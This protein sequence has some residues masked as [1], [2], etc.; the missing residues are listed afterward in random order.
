MNPST[1]S[2]KNI[3]EQVEKVLNTFKAFNVEMELSEV[4]DG[5]RAL[6][7][8]LKTKEPVRM[9]AI[10][11]FKDDL[12]YALGSK[13]IEIE[14]PVRGTSQIGVNILKELTEPLV[15]EWKAMTSATTHDNAGESFSIPFGKDEFGSDIVVD[16]RTLPHM[17]VAGATGSGKSVLLHSIINSLILKN[18]PKKLRLI[19]D[20]AKRVEFG[21]YNDLPHLIAPVITNIKTTLLALKWLEGEMVRRFNVL[22]SAEVL[23]ITSYNSKTNDSSDP[24]E[25]MPHIVMVIDE[26]ADC[27][28]AYPKEVE[29]LVIRLAQLSRAVGIHLIIATSRPS[30]KI[31][32]GMMKAN[33]PTRLAFHV[34]SLSDSRSILDVRGAERLLGAGDAL[35]FTADMSEPVRIQTLRISDDEVREN[36]SGI[37]NKYKDVSGSEK[38]VFNETE[39]SDE[40]NGDEIYLDV[41]S[42]I[43]ANGK[44]STSFIQRKFG[45]GYAR[46]ARLM[47]TLE[48]RGVI[49][50]GDGAGPRKV[51]GPSTVDE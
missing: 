21:M 23:D 30:I 42:A 32:T 28:S 39:L 29:E 35:L 46:A 50:E 3:Q 12:C 1:I 51:I 36:V 6:H 45:I 14:A 10:K 33:I 31:V 18:G 2:D 7:I 49:E 40:E 26:L 25:T 17:L 5:R 27:M 11:E 9:K 19:L 47:D 15:I 34:A 48:E 37:K 8:L 22:E 13:N 38:I 24:V 41:E 20:D 16:I 4:K 43:R 44:A